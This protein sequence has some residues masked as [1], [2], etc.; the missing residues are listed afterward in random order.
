MVQVLKLQTAT[1]T[2]SDSYVNRHPNEDTGSSAQSIT[3]H[4]DMGPHLSVGGQGGGG[5]G[6]GWY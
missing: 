1:T 4:L 2:R 3:S 6:G 5:G